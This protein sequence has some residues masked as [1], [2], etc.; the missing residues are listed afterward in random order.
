MNTTKEKVICGIQQVGI[1]VEDLQTAWKWYNKHLNIQIP[2]VDDEGVA[3]RMLPYTGGKPQPRHAILAISQ[4]GGG[5]FEIWQPKGRKVVYPKE[6]L[7]LGDLGINIC[8]VKAKDVQRAYNYFKDNNRTLLSDISVS[9]L[10]LEHFYMQ[11]P[12]GNIFEIEKDDYCFINIDQHTGGSNGVVIG[13]SDMDRSIEFYKKL[14]DYDV[15]AFDKTDIF[16]DF[17]NLS[18]GKCKIRRVELRRSK[19]VCGPLSEL[20]GNSH[21]E[22]VQNFDIEA[23]KTLEG[24]WWGDPGFIHLCF[25]VRNMDKV[26]EAA[27]SLGHDF[28]CDSGDNFDMGEANGHFTYVED[29]DGTLL[30]FVETFKIPVIKKLGISINLKKRDDY[31]PLPRI[32]TKA[33]KL[34]KVSFD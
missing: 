23:H 33:L 22:L 20:M 10:G 6:P 27:L 4:R 19:P 26:R 29:P 1:G 18:G 16:D 21:L 24:R 8:K 7:R 2:I 11:D 5:G 9:P 13:V 31:K 3:E 25:D 34:M 28:V 14:L 17:S 15:V 32:I 30:E 12:W